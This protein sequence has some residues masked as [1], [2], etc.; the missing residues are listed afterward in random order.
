MHRR[1][2]AADEALWAREQELLDAMEQI[3]QASR[4]EPDA[5]LRALIDWIREHQCP[6]LPEFGRAPTTASR[7]RGRSGAC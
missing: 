3:A 1:E 2:A 5:K 7:R 6:G 4:Y